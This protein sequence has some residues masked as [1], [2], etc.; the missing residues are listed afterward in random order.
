MNTK[1]KYGG[2]IQ[3]LAVSVI[4]NHSVLN[5]RRYLFWV[6]RYPKAGS[7]DNITCI[8]VELGSTNSFFCWPTC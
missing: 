7:A 6:I 1:Q 4:G 5:G 2:E 8:K 3:L